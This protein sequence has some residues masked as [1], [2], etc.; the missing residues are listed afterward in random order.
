MTRLDF[1]QKEEYISSHLFNELRWLLNAA[2][3]WSLQKQL[4]LEICGYDIQVYAMDSAVLHARALF[5][6]FVQP[7]NGNHYSSEQFFDTPSPL[8]SDSYSKNWKATLNRFLM[9]AN[10]RSRPVP[11][12]STG[13]DKDL[14]EMPVDFAREVLRLWVEFEGKLKASKDA[15]LGELARK[16]REQAIKSADC[17]VNSSVAQQQAENKHLRLQP[18]FVF[19]S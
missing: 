13:P 3:E 19:T 14:N 9:H 1:K 17:V 2:T 11:L 18:V 12:K 10:D 8:T 6:F 16:M 7:A 15:E 5:E 4:K